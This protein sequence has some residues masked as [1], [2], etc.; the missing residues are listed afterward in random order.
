MTEASDSKK[1]PTCLLVLGKAGVGKTTFVRKMVDVLSSQSRSPYVINLDPACLQVPYP[2]NIDIRTTVNYKEVMSQFN[3]GPNGAI[4]TSLNLFTTVLDQLMKFV[5]ERAK[6]NEYI[7]I[8]TPGQM[9]VFN[10]SASGSIITKALASTY[11]T[12]LVFLLDLKQCQHP[13]SL[14]TNLLS[15]CSIMFL[16]KLPILAVV[17]KLDQSEPTNVLN[18]MND[19]S[20]FRLAFDSIPGLLGSINS[21]L[22]MVLADLTEYFYL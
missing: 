12:I 11:P 9:E 21:S 22:C 19:F 13:N 5:D 14:L 18:W 17:N 7:I 1:V 2:A 3:L 6:D 8:D 16:H 4:T 10:W 20:E 15:C